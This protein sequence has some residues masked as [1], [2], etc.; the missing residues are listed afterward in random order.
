MPP[1]DP[2]TNPW[3]ALRTAV[4]APEKGYAG[5]AGTAVGTDGSGCKAR[6]ASFCAASAAP[7]RALFGRRPPARSRR[8]LTCRAPERTIRV[9]GPAPLLGSAV[10][11]ASV[12]AP[13]RSHPPLLRGAPRL[14]GAIG[15]FARSSH[16]PRRSGAS[17]ALRGPRARRRR[18]ASSHR[19]CPA[20]R[21]SSNP[22]VAAVKTSRRRRRSFT[23]THRYRQSGAQHFP[24]QHR[25][26]AVPLVAASC[27]RATASC[28]GRFLVLPMP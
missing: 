20:L 14:R 28:G 12:A 7:R 8:P 15:G 4:G 21:P 3:S 24:T 18:E 26:G 9:G 6:I 23:D 16:Q 2:R 19:G 27:A 13:S 11:G 17:K 5:G 10:R 1:A 22:V 25:P